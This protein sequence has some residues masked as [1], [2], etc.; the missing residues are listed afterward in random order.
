MI[1][2]FYATLCPGLLLSIEEDSNT[3]R[4]QRM[5]TTFLKFR[6]M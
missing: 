1:L 5:L 6:L 4:I 3:L 2:P